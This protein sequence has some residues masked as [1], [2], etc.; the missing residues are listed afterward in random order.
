MQICL[1]KF[2]IDTCW[3]YNLLQ[4]K[5]NKKNDVRLSLGKDKKDEYGEIKIMLCLLCLSFLW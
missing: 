1:G 5:E 4:K 2:S 3:S